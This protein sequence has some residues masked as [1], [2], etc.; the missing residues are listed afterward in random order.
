MGPDIEGGILIILKSVYGL[1]TSGARWYEC[2]ADVLLSLGFEP[3]KAG[4]SIWMRLNANGIYDFIAIYVDNLLVAAQDP[5]SIIASIRVIL[6]LKGEG[7]PDYYLGGNIEHEKC[8]FTDSGETLSIRATTFIHGLA[9]KVESLM[10]K[11]RHY[12]T[13]MDSAYHP[14]IDNSSLLVGDEIGMYRMLVGSLQ[15]AVT[16]C[17]FDVAYATN[18]LARY[19]SMPREG[20]LKAAHRAVAYLKHYAKRR[21]LYDTRTPQV[22]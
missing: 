9:E 20:H 14:E 15:W 3:C 11:F 6:N 22:K 4:V 2:L 17:R 12:S 21:F 16:L 8:N 1:K 13:P 18:T 19:T 7:I 5:V 10:G